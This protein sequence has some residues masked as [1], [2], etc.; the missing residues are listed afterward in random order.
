MRQR[1]EPVSEEVYKEDFQEICNKLLPA[2]QATRSGRKV[3]RLEYI[4]DRALVVAHTQKGRDRKIIDL[5]MHMNGL[6]AIEHIAHCL[7]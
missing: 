3:E 5:S 4:S 7:K 6:S 2:L 1:L